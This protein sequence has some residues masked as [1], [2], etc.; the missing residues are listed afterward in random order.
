MIKSM[1]TAIT[2]LRSNNLAMGVIGN[3]VANIN[4]W[5][6]KAQR[7]S[8]ADILGASI[9]N[10]RVGG[11]TKL[12]NITPNFTQ[13]SVLNTGNPLDMAIDGNG[14]F[15]VK[16]PL[17]S[18]DYYTRVGQ[19]IVDDT[20]NVSTPEG[21]VLQGWKIDE[22]GNIGTTLENINLANISSLPKAT[23]QVQIGMNLNKEDSVPTQAW[24]LDPNNGPATDSYNYSTNTVVYDAYGTAHTVSLY[25]R[26]TADNTWEVHYVYK[27]D[28]DQYV[29]AG[30]QTLTFNSD[31]AGSLKSD[32]SSTPIQFTD[33]NIDINFDYGTGT[34]EG[35]S[36]LDGT[37]QFS[38]D[39]NISFIHQNGQEAGS[40]TRDVTIDED[41]YLYGI[42]SN[43]TIR[44]LYK[45]PIAKFS[46]PWNL[47]ELG[48]NVY[49]ITNKSGQPI[50]GNA[51]IGG[52][53][54]ILS[55][56]LEQSNVDLATEFTNLI[57]SQRAFQANAR[58]IT[59]ADELLTELVNIKR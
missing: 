9:G 6:F 52:R 20:G 13:G 39:S 53:G 42:F 32:N 38:Q 4:T 5:G 22:D 59:T 12:S 51:G 44:P 40:L 55:G 29:D 17:E 33:W 46:S 48:N 56:Y 31:P 25:F 26:K 28:S 45:I 27:N 54:K 30:T 21:Y 57:L 23:S 41:G 14:F 8:F 35:G 3:N 11:G 24:N 34:D 10:L 58:I 7:Y 2:G 15:I 36:G 18:A 16:N 19:F 49:G 47:E 43:G 37:T 1:F 50:I